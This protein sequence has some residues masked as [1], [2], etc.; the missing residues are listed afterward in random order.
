MP[1]RA[2]EPESR[3]V[4]LKDV[5]LARREFNELARWVEFTAGAEFIILMKSKLALLFR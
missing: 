3:N 5:W 2:S 4:A 1:M